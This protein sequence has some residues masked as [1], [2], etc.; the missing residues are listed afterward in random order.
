MIIKVIHFISYIFIET[1]HTKI[2]NAN[3][4]EIFKTFAFIYSKYEKI[5]LSNGLEKID[6]EAF[7]DC[8]NLKSINNQ[9]VGWLRVNGT[10]IE[11]PVVQ[12]TDN[13]G[14]LT[15]AA[16][17][18]ENDVVSSLINYIKIPKFNSLH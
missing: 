16:K 13:Q 2:T 1:K 5:V 18:D 9:V 15:D 6:S 12:I 14:N 3:S 4:L 11:Y 8:K 7:K 17:I 10:Q